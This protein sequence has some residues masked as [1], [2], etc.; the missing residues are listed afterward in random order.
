MKHRFLKTAA[1]A[2]LLSSLT[3]SYGETKL[4]VVE[5]LGGRYYYYEVKKDDSL[6]GISKMFGWDQQELKRLNPET[7][8]SLR[9]G[10]KLYYPV[11]ESSSATGNTGNV[12]Q[13]KSQDQMIFH[14]VKRGETV[15]GIS[16]LYGVPVER[17]YAANPASKRG[18][19]AGEN[20][21]IPS[22]DNAPDSDDMIYY[23]I[24]PGDTLYAVSK[25][26]HTTVEDIMRANPG[27]SDRNFKSGATIRITPG[28]E[29]D[30][31]TYRE[32]ERDTISAFDSYKVQKGDTWESIASG[33]GSVIDE[34]QLRKLN[35]GGDKP[36][37]NSIISLPVVVTVKDTVNV[38]EEDPRSLTLEGRQELYD[39][40]NNVSAGRSSEDRLVA[41]TLLLE[42]PSAVRDKE[43]TKGF[44][45][46]LNKLKNEDYKIRLTVA[47]GR[48][49][50]TN[51]ASDTLLLASD[52][53]I[54]TSEK[55]IPKEVVAA[56]SDRNIEIANVFDLKNEDFLD[57]PSMIQIMPP[58]SY[59]NDVV[60]SNVREK[61][62]DRTILFIDRD[63]DN[64]MGLAISKALEDSISEDITLAALAEYDFKPGN[65]YLIYSSATKRDDVAEILR[66]V[67]ETREKYP[68]VTI[69]LMGRPNWIVFAENY[70]SEMSAADTYIPS[71]FYFDKESLD[72]K[73][74]LTDYRAMYGGEPV[75][76]F[77][78]YAVCGY[79]MA[80]TFIPGVAKNG[81]DFTQGLPYTRTLQNY[82][83][84][85]RLSNW[86]GFINTDSCLIHYSAGGYTDKIRIK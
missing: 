5:I 48:K 7:S 38:I 56:L 69:S 43:F 83:D 42:D 74:F 62:G 6:Y 64:D 29:R 66:L 24:K 59:F 41:V 47:D 78:S 45:V 49:P 23:I 52:V 80:V 13:S 44:L 54:S 37:K 68:F 22:A 75:K 70:G 84:L 11:E 18:I 15:Y 17:I 19:E 55:V 67:G 76:S 61:F 50:A 1:A 40:I 26:Y 33:T 32:V 51:I 20:L 28:S 10:E 2:V 81:G 3:M 53:V 77:P 36:K 25:K 85:H 30:N 65:S 21:L 82:M 63:N 57:N 60:A 16:R 14:K 58:S 31:V 4:P 35:E 86:S 71:R 73:D 39:S 46:G 79:D 72:A 8:L 34:D 9:K 12:S 27:I